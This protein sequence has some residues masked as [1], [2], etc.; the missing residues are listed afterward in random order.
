M[1]VNTQAWRASIVRRWHASH[2]ARLCRW[3]LD[4]L[5]QMLPLFLRPWFSGDIE[6]HVIASVGDQWQWCSPHAT[7]PL[8]CWSD[9]EAEAQQR[10]VIGKAL[11]GLSPDAAR[12]VLLVPDAWV[13]R[14]RVTFPLAARNTLRQVASYEIDRQTPFCVADVVYEI[15]VPAFAVNHGQLS[16]ELIVVPRSLLDPLLAR[17]RELGIVLDAVDVREGDGRKGLNLLPA[18][19]VPRRT[20]RR[21]RLNLI[22]LAS[23]V[24]LCTFSMLQWVHNRELAL[25]VMQDEVARMQLEGKA[26]SV[27]RQ[28]LQDH[29]G[30]KGFLAER[31]KSRVSTLSIL[32]E[33]SIRL[34]QNAWLERL[35]ID[36]AG[37]VGMQGQGT[38][39]ALLLEALKGAA[40]LAEPAFQGSIQK[41]A[42]TSK[43]RFYMVA[44]LRKSNDGKPKAA[45][46]TPAAAGSTP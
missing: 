15:E 46:A 29:A 39:A 34:P 43:E 23:A 4:E 32:Q 12:F 28:E 6:W 21:A 36:P 18:A 22:L 38:Q 30:A 42:V 2:G 26:V 14:R 44:Q 45:P 5:A 24:L 35:N 31:K 17:F 25:R 9:T 7:T 13:L 33:L 16:T 1:S 8:A 11:D 41:D 20:N 40:W 27:L 19:D 10:D 37:Q 3:W